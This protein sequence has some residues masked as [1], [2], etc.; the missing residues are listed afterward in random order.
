MLQGVENLR[1]RDLPR[2][3]IYQKP[4]AADGIPAHSQ[5]RHLDRFMKTDVE[6]VPMGGQNDGQSL[7]PV[8]KGCS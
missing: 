6:L 4:V 7:K 2:F 3:I 5:F 1:P 8:G